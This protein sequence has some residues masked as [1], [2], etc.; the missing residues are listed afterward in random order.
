[1]AKKKGTSW[2]TKPLHR[3]SLSEPEVKRGF[4]LIALLTLVVIGGLVSGVVYSYHWLGRSDFFQVT[5]IDI[6]GNQE[7]SKETIIQLAGVDVHANLLALDLDSIAPRIRGYGWIESVNLRK[8]W[9][10]RLRIEVRERRP[11]ALLN[12]PKG[13]YYVDSKG[14]PFAPLTGQ[15]ELDFPIITGLE[16]AL[17]FHGNSVQIQIDGAYDKVQAILQFIGF[18]R[19]GSSSLPA[20]NI[21]QVHFAAD[22]GVILFL[23]DR[24]FPIYLGQE[25]GKKSYTRLAKVLYWLYKKKEFQTVAYIRLDYME[26]KIL[27]GTDT[28]KTSG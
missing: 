20:Q 13:L 6:I 24:P 18:A 9:P 1:M 19:R 22:H 10:S 3:N 17:T 25:L 28:D 27:V 11:V 14:D 7:V 15:A 8:E 4:L 21:S 23:A 26:N 2:T 5:S 12:T 16:N